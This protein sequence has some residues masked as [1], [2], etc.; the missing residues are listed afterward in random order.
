VPPLVLSLSN[1]HRNRSLLAENRRLH[2]VVEL[3]TI[4]A[5]ELGAV[6]DRLLFI[7]QYANDRLSG[8]AGAPLTRKPDHAG[9]R[10]ISEPYHSMKPSPAS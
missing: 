4:R 6:P 7:K 10:S 5:E 2:R 3:V 8:L 1:R 9:R